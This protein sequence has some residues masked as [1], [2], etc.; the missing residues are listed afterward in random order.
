MR[1]AG[2][3]RGFWRFGRLVRV[4]VLVGGRDVLVPVSDFALLEDE[5]VLLR[6]AH[7]RE[8]LLDSLVVLLTLLHY[9]ALD[10]GHVGHELMELAEEVVPAMMRIPSFLSHQLRR[11]LNSRRR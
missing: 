2:G 3:L 6:L 8:V 9:R 4:K 7:H 10:F 11:V 5:L 1:G